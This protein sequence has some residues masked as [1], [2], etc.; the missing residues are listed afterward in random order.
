MSE[1]FKYE[2]AKD[3]GFYETVEREGWSGIRTKDAGNM[4]KRAIQIAEQALA[5]QTAAPASRPPYAGSPVRQAATPSPGQPHIPAM[6]QSATFA[7]QEA[8]RPAPAYAAPFLPYA[9]VQP[10]PAS[11]PYPGH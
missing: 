5:N 1:Q 7:S 6:V 9:A 4:V 11:A 8:Q 2:L 10:A 3:L